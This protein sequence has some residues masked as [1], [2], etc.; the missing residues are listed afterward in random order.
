MRTIE[1]PTRYA[2]REIPR[3]KTPFVERNRDN[4]HTLGNP[5]WDRIPAFPKRERCWEVVRPAERQLAAEILRQFR[6]AESIRAVNDIVA[7]TQEATS[8]EASRDPEQIVRARTI[9]QE[10]SACDHGA[11]RRAQEAIKRLI[12]ESVDLSVKCL[13]RCIESFD[14][15]LDALALAREND[16]T[17]LGIPLFREEMPRGNPIID[18]HQTGRPNVVWELWANKECTCLH[19]CREICR[20]LYQILTIGQGE[21]IAMSEIKNARAIPTLVFLFTDEDASRFNWL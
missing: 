20:N 8:L 4:R 21:H 15:E 7:R 9:R 10:I 19:S 12:D 11:Y 1:K 13:E 5:R 18:G 17:R 16:M 2:T 14:G 6:A 3:C